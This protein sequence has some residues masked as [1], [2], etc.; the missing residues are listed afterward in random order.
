MLKIPLVAGETYYLRI[1]GWSGAWGTMSLAVE[2]TVYLFQ[3]FL[4][5]T[6]WFWEPNQ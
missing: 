3:I 2:R 1:H 4:P 6:N 5:I